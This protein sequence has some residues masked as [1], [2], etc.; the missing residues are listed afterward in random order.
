MTDPV[1]ALSTH[2]VENQPGPPPGDLR[3]DRPLVEAVAHL[4]A[5]AARIG[6]PQMRALGRAARRPVRH[7]P[8]RPGL[9][10]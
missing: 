3:A 6:T 9:G 10:T 2:R 4:A 7:P 1:S 5:H 8:T